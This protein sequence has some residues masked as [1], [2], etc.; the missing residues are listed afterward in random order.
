[1]SRHSIV[2]RVQTVAEII[3]PNAAYP[4]GFDADPPSVWIEHGGQ[5]VMPFLGSSTSMTV[6]D[7]LKLF[8]DRLDMSP[9]GLAGQFR[10]VLAKLLEAEKAGAVGP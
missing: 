3:E 6:V 9:W 10:Q 1:V 8:M 5:I 2:C 7:T 4:I